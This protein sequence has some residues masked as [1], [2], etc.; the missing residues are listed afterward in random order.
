M[1]LSS[2]KKTVDNDLI[3]SN[4]LE[5]IFSIFP[6]NEPEDIENLIECLTI[7]NE[8]LSTVK[9]TK[10]TVPIPAKQKSVINCHTNSYTMKAKTSVL[11]EPEEGDA[12]PPGLE[13]S[14]MILQISRGT[15]NRIKLEIESTTSSRKNSLNPIQP[16]G[17]GHYGS[18][19]ETLLD[20][21]SAMKN[22]TLKL[23]E[24]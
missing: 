11:F 3:S 22:V 5:V 13:L 4:L 21:I 20:S 2:K 10:R 23:L 19:Y 6:D 18:P 8:F 1:I 24:F 17:G 9:S 16:G 14:R 7:Q 12:L 15:S